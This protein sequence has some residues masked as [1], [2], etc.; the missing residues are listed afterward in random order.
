MV[1]TLFSY[2]WMERSTDQERALWDK[3]AKEELFFLQH[4]TYPHVL[5]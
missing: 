4:P 5:F 3:W 1:K 2:L